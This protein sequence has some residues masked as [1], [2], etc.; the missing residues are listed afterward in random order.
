KQALA[1]YRGSLA[2]VLDRFYQ[3]AHLFHADVIIRLTAD[4]P[5]IDPE[6]IDRTI[7]AFL[8]MPDLSYSAH[9][10]QLP[11]PETPNTFHSDFTADRLPPPWQRTLPIG[12]DVE[13][14]SY[15]ALQHAWEK[16]DQTYQ[17]E[18]VMPYLYEGV[19][20]PGKLPAQGEWHIDK[21]ATP[22]GFKVALL[23]H[24]PDYGTLRWTVDTPADLEFVRQ[25]YANFTH[26]D[27]FGWK[28]ILQLLEDKPELATINAE[29]KHK[30]AFDV[31]ERIENP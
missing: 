9:A 26:S 30:S 20:F 27:D 21:G 12:L 17:R 2:D 18:H 1:C 11:D 5:L 25:V 29:I 10:T 7:S 28:E 4:C 23:N 24:T 13:V 15:A 3:A 19:V 16:A 14:C 31:D 22:R 6:I 8:G